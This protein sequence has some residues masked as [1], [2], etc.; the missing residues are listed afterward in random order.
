MT[1]K[2]V[3]S[4]ACALGVFS[5]AACGSDDPGDTQSPGGT[6]EI[7]ADETTVAEAP[8]AIDTSDGTVDVR[9]VDYAY[10]DVPTSVAAGTSFALTN[11]SDEEAHELV[12]VRL[13]DDE[14][15]PVAELVA[16]PP[17]DFGPLM[18]GVRTVV[19]AAP[20]DEGI[21]VVGDGTLAEPGRYALLCIIPT[22]ADP[23]EYLTSAATSDGPPDV[24]GG[25]PHMV[26]G[27]FAEITVTG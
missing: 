24:P 22:G 17:E 3:L 23:E 21:A 9:A 11:E 13:P 25:P 16:L 15:R 27:M 6:A 10:L 14:Q 1:S 4:I 19:L 2:P 8:T 5:F 26:A 20:G 12:A 7:A 18:D